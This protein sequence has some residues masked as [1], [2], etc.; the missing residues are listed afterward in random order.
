MFGAHFPL[1]VVAGTA[2]GTASALLVAIAFDR[3]RRAHADRLRPSRSTDA[4]TVVAVMPS[5]NDVPEP[6]LVR[7]VLEHVDSLVIVD[8]G[9]RP[10]VAEQLDALAETFGA[11]L[12]RQPE[13]GGK[14]T[15]VR[16]GIDHA[17]GARRRARDRRRRAA[18][19][20]GDPAFVAPRARRARDR[21][22][23][24]RPR[25]DA[26]AA[27]HRQPHRPDGSSSS[28]PVARFA[29][30]RTACGCSA[31]RAL[32]AAPP[33]GGYEAETLHLPPRP[34]RRRAASP[35]SPIPAIYGEE[36][37]SFRPA[38]DSLRCC[39]HLVRPL[40]PATPSQSR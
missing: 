21:R 18:S 38:T 10:D 5:H 1:D 20:R 23:L 11:Q 15:A 16:A 13:Q 14:G 17:R 33:S 31:G 6:A 34:P 37:S 26:P 8:D 39:G 27:P 9:S 24:R 29:T 22:P 25:P 7:T 4:H 32:G 36:R 19:R 3:R 2:L 35:G 30:R 12:V 40:E 28:R